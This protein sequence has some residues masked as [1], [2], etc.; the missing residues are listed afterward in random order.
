MSQILETIAEALVD[1]AVS[2]VRTNV[3][4]AV[5]EGI[6]AKEILNDGLLAGMD[7]VSIL[8]KDGEM[9]VPEVLVSAKA[10]QAGVEIIKPLLLAAGVESSA[11]IL[12]VT[13]EGDLHDIGIKLVGMM[14]EGAGFE[15]INIGVDIPAAKI[16]E[17][18]KEIKPDIVGLS[19][20]LTTTMATMKDVIDAL[21]EEGL[22]ENMPVM[23]GG[24]PLS[25][26][27]AEKIGGYYSS[28]ANEAVTVA[29]QL[30]SVS[31]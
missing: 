5:D 12:M 30:L 8:F 29:K 23:V 6:P 3:Q 13:V 9:F 26:M 2:T 21:K 16:V 28:D 4:K 22:T 19:A 1:G 20:M 25:P 17:K 24:A 31:K 18:V 11:K 10:M 15:V 27:Y 14:L 7:E